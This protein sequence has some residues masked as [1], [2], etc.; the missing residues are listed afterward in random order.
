MENESAPKKIAASKV[1]VIDQAGH[2]IQQAKESDGAPRGFSGP[3]GGQIRVIQGGPWMLLVLPLLI[4]FVIIGF[5]ILMVLTLFFG[6][7]MFKMSGR[8]NLR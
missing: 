5:F 1:E 2:T 8:R 4:P 7:S 6:R 3:F